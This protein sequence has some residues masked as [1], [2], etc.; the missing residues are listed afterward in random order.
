MG[1]VVFLARLVLAAVFL[2]AGMAKVGDPAGSQQ[3]MRD[4]GVPRVLAAPMGMLLPLAEIAVGIALLPGTTAFWGA[5]AALGLLLVFVAGMLYN[6]AQGR[7]P[8]CH[9]FGQIHSEPVGKSS[10]ARNVLLAA[11][12]V[13]VVARGYDGAQALG[14]FGDATAADNIGIILGVAGFLLIVLEGRILF[15]LVRQNGRLL[16]ILETLESMDLVPAPVPGLDASAPAVPVPAAVAPAPAPPARGLPVGTPAPAFRLSGLFGETIPLDALRAAGKPVMLLFVNPGC[17]PCNAL[18]PDVKRWQ[19]ELAPQLTIALIS[20]D[21]ADAN[22]PKVT[23]HG[24]TNVLL[25]NE[26]EVNLLYQVNGTPSAVVI[27]ADGRIQSPLA[28]GAEQIQALIARS[29]Q[30]PVPDEPQP[31]PA[32]QAVNGYIANGAPAAAAPPA[33]APTPV[34][35]AAPALTV[36]VVQVQASVGDR[37]PTVRLPNLNGKTV[38]LAGFRG[39]RTLVLFWNPDCG[40]CQRMLDDLKAWEAGPPAGAPKLLVVSTGTPDKNR[41]Q[42]IRSTVVLDQTFATGRSFGV[43]GTPSAVLVDESGR[44]ASDVAVGAPAVL[45]LAGVDQNQ[46]QPASA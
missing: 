32:A 34:P 45:A 11:L 21:S 10:I 30:I 9:C 4:F 43:Q 35:P 26:R 17:G 37:A 38:N 5:I 12:A 7:K 24:L 15:R 25:Q 6:L 16:Q 27:S 41:E 42:G 23:E 39:S 13:F 28:E 29:V 19:V 14:R 40:F 46:G 1:T 20:Q 33:P 22:R 2:V 3:A 31:Q 18:L 44:I 36:P 8:D